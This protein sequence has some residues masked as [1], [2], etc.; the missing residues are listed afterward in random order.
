[1]LRRM[2]G[3]LLSGLLFAGCGGTPEPP[4]DA[5]PEVARLV[6]SEPA[7]DSSPI[8]RLPPA[9]GTTHRLTRI[10][11]RDPDGDGIANRR[12]LITEVFDESGVLLER[13]RE[14]DFEA[15]GI[16]DARNVITFGE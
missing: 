1:M 5:Q 12:V 10:I 11:D 16:V 9:S 3:T 8:A 4:P 7:E 15:D 13:I 6:P 14:D 2:T